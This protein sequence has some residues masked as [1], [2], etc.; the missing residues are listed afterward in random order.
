MSRTGPGCVRTAHKRWFMAGQRRGYLE[1]CWPQRAL[2]ASRAPGRWAPGTEESH[3]QSRS[4]LS[5]PLSSRLCNRAHHISFGPRP[6]VAEARGNRQRGWCH[7]CSTCTLWASLG[8]P[9]EGWQEEERH[10]CGQRAQPGQ[11]FG[12][13]TIRSLP[14]DPHVWWQDLETNR[15][16]TALTTSLLALK[17]LEQGRS[18]RRAVAPGAILAIL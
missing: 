10:S 14:R 4:G 13:G 18:E 6:V 9:A 5:T 3:V 11:R 7:E 1:H 17:S 12:G 2:K 15:R 16:D 8:E